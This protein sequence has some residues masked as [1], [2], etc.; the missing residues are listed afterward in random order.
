MDIFVYSWH[1]KN[2]KKNADGGAEKHIC[3]NQ[4]FCSLWVR[5]SDCRSVFF[6]YLSSY[7]PTHVVLKKYQSINTF[8]NLCVYMC[9]SPYLAS[10]ATSTSALAVIGALE[11]PAVG[12]SVFS[13][14]LVELITWRRRM[15][16]GAMSTD[17]SN[18]FPGGSKLK[19]LA[20]RPH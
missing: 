12:S 7:C 19:R 2:L 11:C 14:P 17:V 4:Y 13:S 16:D 10:S 3:S 5:K 15:E 9:V 1:F 8:D 20:L 6:K 18:S